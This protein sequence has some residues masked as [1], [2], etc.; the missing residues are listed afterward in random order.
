MNTIEEILR[1][2]NIFEYYAEKLCVTCNNRY[3]DKDLCKITKRLD[4]TVKCDNYERCM[5]NKC[6]TCK[7]EKKCFS[8]TAKQNKPIMKG[9]V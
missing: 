1:S 6:K 5:T 8:V 9:L 2:K 3:N 4:N 7:D